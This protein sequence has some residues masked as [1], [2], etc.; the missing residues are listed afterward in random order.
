MMTRSGKLL[1]MVV[2][3]FWLPL[4]YP[5]TAKQ[6]LDSLKT[7]RRRDEF[8]VLVTQS[9]EDAIQSPLMPTILQQTPTKVF[10]PNPDAEFKTPDGG[11]YSRVGVTEKE[12][13]VLRGL[14]LQSRT[15]L[16]KQGSQAS[17]VKLNLNA[18]SEYIAVMAMAAEEFPL[19]E[20]A[21]KAVGVAPDDWVPEYLRLRRAFKAQSKV[22]QPQQ[23]AAS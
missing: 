2:E 8:V 17:V 20:Q 23:S 9:P 22:R 10:L 3:E 5:T 1:A 13:Q 4:M 6:I 19:L 16:V 7:G 21:K 14:G 18:L 11:G 15:F 12:F